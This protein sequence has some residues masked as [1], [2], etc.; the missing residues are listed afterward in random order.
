M[1]AR[2]TKLACL[3]SALLALL[4]HPVRADE[5]RVSP[6]RVEV[7][8][9]LGAGTRGFER[10]TPNGVQVLETTPFPAA[11]LA[12]RVDTRRNESFQLGALLRYRTSLA[13]TVETEPLFALSREVPARSSHFELSIVPALRLGD[14]ADAPRVA[15]PVGLS[16]RTFWTETHDAAT[17]GYSLIGPHL[18]PELVWPLGPITLRI[19]PE[20]QWIVAIDRALRRDGASGQ[21]VSIG[22]EVSLALEL[23]RAFSLEVSYRQAHAL[24]A[25]QGEHADFDDTERYASLRLAGGF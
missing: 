6:T 8:A 2:A 9:G 3:A 18:R 17:F 12:L 14:D 15:L 19:G 10:P 7:S 16:A 5:A 21:G 24:I 23:H 4:A 22:A 20:A 13:M 11:D 1:S 25:G